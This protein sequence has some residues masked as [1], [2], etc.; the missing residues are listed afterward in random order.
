MAGRPSRGPT[1]WPPS[2]S[3]GC[4]GWARVARARFC[5]ARTRAPVWCDA[6]SLAT[7]WPR[8]A[9]PAA[10]HDAHRRRRVRHGQEG[11][12]AALRTALRRAIG[13]CSPRA[14]LGICTCRAARSLATHARPHAALVAAPRGYGGSLSHQRVAGHFRAASCRRL[15]SQL[16]SLALPPFFARRPAAARCKPFWTAWLASPKTSSRRAA[17]E[18]PRAAARRSGAQLPNPALRCTSAAPDAPLFVASDRHLRRR[19]HLEP[20]Y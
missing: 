5:A 11:A 8:P 17:A 1:A 16:M 12:C 15:A 3:H 14:V 19:R 18:A 10:A 7:Q 9:P 4:H 2:A 13:A 6:A 20:A